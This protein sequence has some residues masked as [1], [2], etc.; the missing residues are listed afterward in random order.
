MIFDKSCLAAGEGSGGGW[1][2]AIIAVRRSPLVP[3]PPMGGTHKPYV[4][5]PP[6]PI[7]P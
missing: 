7:E 1:K 2:T 4:V 3:Q 5:F 6:P